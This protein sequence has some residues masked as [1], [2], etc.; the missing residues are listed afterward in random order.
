MRRLIDA[1]YERAHQLLVE[2]RA[3]LDLLATTLLE[4]EVL[5]GE[6]V[7]KL[8]GPLTPQPGPSSPVLHSG[9]DR[10]NTPTV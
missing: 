6:M 2:H 3:Q 7:K 10:P 4:K 8:V 9:N 1:C 5:D